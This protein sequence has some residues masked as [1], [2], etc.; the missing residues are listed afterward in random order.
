MMMILN[1]HGFA[2]SKSLSFCRRPVTGDYLLARKRIAPDSVYLAALHI[3][4]IREQ[5]D[6][7]RMQK[8]IY[9]N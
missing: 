7:M 4:A 9:F 1:K 8:L 2:G 6:A 3:R 5:E